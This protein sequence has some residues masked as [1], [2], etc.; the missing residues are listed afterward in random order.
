MGSKFIPSNGNAGFGF[1]LAAAFHQLQLTGPMELEAL[2]KA[3]DILGIE[4]SL[5]Y[6]E[7]H[8]LATERHTDDPIMVSQRDDSTGGLP[9]PITKSFKRVPKRS[10][11]IDISKID[12]IMA[13]SQ[14]SSRLIADAV[15][16][17]SALVDFTPDQTVQPL[18]VGPSSISQLVKHMIK[19]MSSTKDISRA[20][21]DAV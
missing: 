10:V 9:I 5:L 18:V 11:T 4:R 19:R 21:F 2:A 7:Y 13:E 15:S 12:A 8:H 6:S 20:A 16:D 1:A 14:V 3:F 17:T